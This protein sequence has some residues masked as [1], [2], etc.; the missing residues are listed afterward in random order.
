M[1]LKLNGVLH[2]QYWL[3]E[4][5]GDAETAIVCLSHLTHHETLRD[6]RPVLI[7]MRGE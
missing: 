5:V 2:Q 7:I 1:G 6:C 3:G 4:S